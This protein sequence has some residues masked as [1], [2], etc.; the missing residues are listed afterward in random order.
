MK[1]MLEC[2][3]PNPCLIANGG[4]SHLCLLSAVDPRGYSCSCPKG[5]VLD[6]DSRSCTDIATMLPLTQHGKHLHSTDDPHYIQINEVYHD[7]GYSHRILY[8]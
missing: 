5:M 2:A 1:Y 3:V 7:N 6:D 8:G 4:C